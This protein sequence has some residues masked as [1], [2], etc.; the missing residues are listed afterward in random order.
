MEVQAHVDT[1]LKDVFA[2]RQTDDK[3]NMLAAASCQRGC[4]LQHRMC[5]FDIFGIDEPT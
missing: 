2:D 3:Q 5:K 4:V 1:H